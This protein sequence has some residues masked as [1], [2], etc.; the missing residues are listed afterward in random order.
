MKRALVSY[1][2]ERERAT[3][4]MI[5]FKRMESLALTRL[6]LSKTLKRLDGSCRKLLSFANIVLAKHFFLEK[7][8]QIALQQSPPQRGSLHF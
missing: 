7:L 3:Y 8:T 1:L 2:I 4:E 5:N 6:R